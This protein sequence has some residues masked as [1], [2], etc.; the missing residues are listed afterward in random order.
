MTVMNL[1]MMKKPTSKWVK[2]KKVPK[3]ELVHRSSLI[4]SSYPFGIGIRLDDQIW[5]SDE[6]EEPN[7]EELN[8]DENGK[9]SKDD[10]DAHN[11][12]DA[13]KN[14]ENKQGDEKQDGLD[15]ADSKF[16][17]C[18]LSDEFSFHFCFQMKRIRGNNKRMTLT[19]LMSQMWETI[20]SIL[21][22]MNWKSR[23]KPTTW[24]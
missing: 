18:Q 20:R 24:I 16:S 3:G 7:E 12:L 14:D 23:L 21:T 5:G 19:S 13:N 11:D 10:T 4:V 8:D 1:T 2:L 15:A 6:E 9:G 17:T 22:T